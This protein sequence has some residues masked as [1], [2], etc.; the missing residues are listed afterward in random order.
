MKINKLSRNKLFALASIG[1]I[2]V[3]GGGAFAFH[4]LN[5]RPRKISE[6]NTSV[7]NNEAPYDTTQPSD[8]NSMTTDGENHTPT[9]YEGESPNKS[10]SLTGVINYKS[11]ADTTLTIRI[12]IDQTINEG[13]CRLVLTRASDNKSVTK[14]ATIFQNPSSSSCEGF[15]IQTAELG[16]GRWSIEVQ[17]SD[18]TKTGII[19]DSIDI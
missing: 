2:I 7:E 19:K 15:D 6:Q 18:G 5:D 17:L 10:S 1:I 9:Q 16:G 8:S 13:S 4:S 14:D 11:V 3:L 12:T